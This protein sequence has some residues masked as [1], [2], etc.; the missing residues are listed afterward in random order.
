MY[1]PSSQT[2]I[3]SCSSLYS[4]LSACRLGCLNRV[5]RSAARLFGGIP[6]FGHVSEYMRDVLHWLPAEHR[7]SYRIASW[8]GAAYLALLLSTF[9]SSVV[10]SLVLCARD[11][12]AHRSKVLSWSRL[13][14]PPLSRTVLFRDGF[15]HLE[16]ASILTSYFPKSLVACV[17]PT[18]R[19]LSFCRAGVWGA[20]K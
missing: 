20:S 14:V 17:F 19:L 18:L 12:F 13:L 5:L 9:V 4:G 11:R 16:W 15:L 10:L 8:S 2:G 1:M 3:Y 6:K 7:I